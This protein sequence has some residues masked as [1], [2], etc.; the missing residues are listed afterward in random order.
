MMFNRLFIFCVVLIMSQYATF[1]IPHA[2]S[3]EVTDQELETLREQEFEIL[4][5]DVLLGFISFDAPIERVREL[6][7]QQIKNMFNDIIDEVTGNGKSIIYGEPL[8]QESG[9][10][11]DIMDFSLNWWESSKI[12]NIMADNPTKGKDYLCRLIHALT[13]SV[14][15]SSPPIPT[16]SLFN[17]VSIEPRDEVSQIS[18]PNITPPGLPNLRWRYPLERTTT[19]PSVDLEGLFDLSAWRNTKNPNKNWKRNTLIAVAAGG[20]AYLLNR[21]SK[22]EFERT[23]DF[24]YH[25][26]E[27]P[28]PIFWTASALGEPTWKRSSIPAD[29]TLEDWKQRSD[30][31]MWYPTPPINITEIEDKPSWYIPR[32]RDVS[33]AISVG[34]ASRVAY[35]FVRSTFFPIKNFP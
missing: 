22:S 1:I 19:R 21:L 12:W 25:P 5:E 13:G 26:S 4:K 16:L 28:K 8:V 9:D 29:I 31:H 20:L 10:E 11:S 23:E 32:G 3:Q 30:L 2:Y 6:T 15:P 33:I 27:G 17:A 24:A 18:R 34:F 14:P 35:G 7:L